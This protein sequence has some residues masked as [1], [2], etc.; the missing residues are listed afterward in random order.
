METSL[1]NNVDVSTALEIAKSHFK[2]KRWRELKLVSQR[3][4]EARPVQ[5]EAFEWLALAEMELGNYAQSIVFTEKALAVD[6]A[7]DF[8]FST[9]IHAFWCAERWQNGKQMLL[10]AFKSQAYMPE[11]LARIAWCYFQEGDTEQAIQFAKKSLAQCSDSVLAHEVLGNAYYLMGV[12][13]SAIPHYEKWSVLA[14]CVGQAQNNLGA[15]YLK[16]GNSHKALV[17]FE[18]ALLCN[19]NQAEWMYHAAQT[20]QLAGKPDLALGYMQRANLLMPD[21]SDIA[22]AY[23]EL[24]LEHDEADKALPIAA[25]W[26]ETEETGYRAMLFMAKSLERLGREED[27]KRCYAHLEVASGDTCRAEIAQA[28]ES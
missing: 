13:E 27:A 15:A 12:Y 21:R 2:A 7:S 17:C 1:T 16:Q 4:I 9:R 25:Q 6:P 28:T 19:P 20:A 24:L 10:Q 18:H 23:V 26:A 8:A 11:S 5:L 14:P 3:V 22:L